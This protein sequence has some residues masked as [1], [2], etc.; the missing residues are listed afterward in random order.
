MRK[1]EFIENTLKYLIANLANVD[2]SN[3][4]SVKVEKDYEY[5]LEIIVT[6]GVVMESLFNTMNSINDLIG[7]NAAIS[8]GI[9]LPNETTQKD[10]GKQ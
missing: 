8:F 10:D 2:Y 3:I 5:K 6:N 9:G 4:I 1:N 7:S